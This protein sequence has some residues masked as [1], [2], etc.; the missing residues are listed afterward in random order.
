MT[1]IDDPQQTAE[2]GANINNAAQTSTAAAPEPA[3]QSSTTTPWYKKHLILALFFVIVALVAAIVGIVVSQNNSNNGGGVDGSESNKAPQ[4][5]TDLAPSSSDIKPTPTS[6]PSDTPVLLG[7][8]LLQCQPF[9]NPILH[10][11]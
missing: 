6:S 3:S 10:L 11:R 9:N 1:S 7:N 4:Q 5:P 2:E 8:H